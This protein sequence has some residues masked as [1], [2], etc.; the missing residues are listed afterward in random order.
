[1]QALWSGIYPLQLL[2]DW[3]TEA[4]AITSCLRVNELDNASTFYIYQGYFA[5]QVWYRNAN[6]EMRYTS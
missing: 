2:A 4:T 5:R 1:M 3:L 6:P